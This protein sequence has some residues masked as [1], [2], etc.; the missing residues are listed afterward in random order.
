MRGSIVATVILASL[1]F[2]AQANDGVEL[3]LKSRASA[4]ASA[5][6]SASMKQG[7]APFTYGRDPMPQLLLLDELERRGPRGSC[8]F[9]AR[10]LCYDIADAR[11]VYRPARAYMPRINGL[12]PENVTFRANRIIF[13]Y[14]FK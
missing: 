13:K 1:A 9:S 8:E 10:D 6:A 12:T 14:S 5:A 2:A 7:D 11:V 4:S 3:S